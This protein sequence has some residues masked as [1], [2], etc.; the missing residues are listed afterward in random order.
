MRLFNSRVSL[1]LGATGMAAVCDF[2]AVLGSGIV[3]AS[4]AGASVRIDRGISSESPTQVLAAARRALRSV[5]GYVIFGTNTQSGK[6]ERIRVV[7]QSSSWVEEQI[8][9]SGRTFDLRV[10]PGIAFVRANRAYWEASQGS[11]T[12]RRLGGRWVQIPLTLGRHSSPG[13]GAMP[14]PNLLNAWA[15]TEEPLLVQAQ[16]PS[17]GSPRW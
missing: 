8:D 1:V 14:R 5:H 7:E 2:S 9:G 13:V 4:N 16:R 10:L 17:T 6:T 3:A 11:S 12:A 15:R